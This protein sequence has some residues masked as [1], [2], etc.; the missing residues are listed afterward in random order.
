MCC[1]EEAHT[2]CTACVTLHARS[3]I[4]QRRTPGP[5]RL[6]G[7]LQAIRDGYVLDVLANYAAIT[8]R[9]QIAGVNGRSQHT[10]R[11]AG[12]GR[13]SGG[14]G[15]GDD[16]A[17]GESEGGGEAEDG[18]LLAEEEALMEAASNSRD[19]VRRKVRCGKQSGLKARCGGLHEARM[20]VQSVRRC[21]ASLS[22][23]C[24]PCEACST[25]WTYR[26]LLVSSCSSVV[27]HM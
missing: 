10:R 4:Q 14:G 12:A 27:A 19:V 5:A 24:L 16:G 22:L 1:R 18:E 9:L 25:I 17:E 8:P 23:W 11:K 13:R 2:A 26:S 20:A 21:V 3:A 15:G 6:P 7:C